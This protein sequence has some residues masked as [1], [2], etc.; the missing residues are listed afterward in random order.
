[1]NK[2][3][4][5]FLAI[6]VCAI[7]AVAVF[8]LADFTAGKSFATPQ[9]AFDGMQAALKKNDMRG[10]CDCLT[11]DSRDILAATML[12]ELFT[13]KQK[14]ADN[15]LEKHGIGAEA[16]VKMEREFKAVIHPQAPM[17]VKQEAAQTILAPV[18]DRTALVVDIAVLK[19][20]KVF[21]ELKILGE[22]KLGKVQTAGTV[23]VAEISKAGMEGGGAMEFRK[24]GDSWRVNLFPE[25]RQ[26][27][28]DGHP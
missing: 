9:D 8:F 10:F 20:S 13:N 11:D 2:G 14:G 1:M 21:D 22:F 16:L 24:Q 4:G 23:A 19:V 12:A 28:P 26:G 7:L 25:R 15:I 6:I 3:S 17:E 18:K 5:T 27:M